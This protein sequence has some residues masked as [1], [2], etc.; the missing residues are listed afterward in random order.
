MAKFSL[1]F[2]VELEAAFRMAELTIQAG[3]IK[4]VGKCDCE[5]STV[6]K[7]DDVELHKPLK[8]KRIALTGAMVFAAPGVPIA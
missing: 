6:L 2:T 1:V 7:Y 4:Q 3:R 8:S 5:L